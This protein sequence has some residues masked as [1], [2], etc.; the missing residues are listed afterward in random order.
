MKIEESS[1]F[2]YILKYNKGC[3]LTVN[4]NLKNVFSQLF[5]SKDKFD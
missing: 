1:F 3:R 5:S 4:L 2:I